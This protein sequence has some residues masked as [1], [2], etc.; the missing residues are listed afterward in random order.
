MR[1]DK[2]SNYLVSVNIL[3]Y[4]KLLVVVAIRKHHLLSNDKHCITALV[5]R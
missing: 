5:I 3:W 2:N 1:D 4:I